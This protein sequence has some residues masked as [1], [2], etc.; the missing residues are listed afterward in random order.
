M[1]RLAFTM[2]FLGNF[3]REGAV[4]ELLML[5]GL[6]GEADATRGLSDTFGRIIYFVGKGLG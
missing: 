1:G 3:L 6:G 2:A 5:W 4:R